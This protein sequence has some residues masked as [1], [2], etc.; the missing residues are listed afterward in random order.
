MEVDQAVFYSLCLRIW[1]FVAGPVSMILIG[2]FFTPEIQGYYY[3]FSSLMVLQSLFELGFQF[4]IMNVSSHEWA[5]LSL[6]AAGRIRGDAA[7]LSRIVSLGR[8][9]FSWYGVAAALFAVSVGFGGAWFLT[10]SGNSS[11]ISW[12]GPWI[13]LVIASSGLLWTLPFVALLEGCGQ[14]AIVNRYRVYQAVVCNVAVWACILLG[15]GLW[16]AVAAS[17]TRLAWDLLLLLVRYRRFFASLLHPPARERIDWRTELWPMQWRLAVAAPF[18]FLAF[19]LFTP[20]LFHYHGAAVAGRMGMT[21]QLVTML[22]GAALAWV[23]ARGPLFGRLVAKRDFP[24][25]DRVFFR[26]TWISLAV[27]GLGAAA[28]WLGVWGL[29]LTEFRFASR[30]LEPL[31]SALF[32]LAIVCYHV[33]CC[34]TYYLRAHKREWLLPLTLVSSLS[35]GASVW[36]FGSLYGATGMGWSF[37]LVVS[38]VILPWET[39]IWRRCRAAHETWNAGPA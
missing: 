14:I 9:L 23:Q 32:L 19:S 8:L 35:I 21:W 37:L 26:L 28:V 39:V 17:A 11:Q 12:H 15:G 30:L 22:Q 10:Q 4:V 34:Q 1:Q 36:W 27:V 24:E 2:T 25:L 31:P 13:G 18:N 5:H 3:T 16:T 20:V 33:P 38:C 6:D 7:A 29:Y